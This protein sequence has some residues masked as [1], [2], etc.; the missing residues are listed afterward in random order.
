MKKLTLTN[1]G[2]FYIGKHKFKCYNTCSID[3]FLI[4]VYLL[5]ESTCEL[6]KFEEKSGN[7]F[8]KI[9]AFL[10]D[11]DWNMA[12]N[13]W[14]NFCP[15]LKHIQKKSNFNWFL[16]EFD[17]FFRYF[18]IYQTYNWESYCN[19]TREPPCYRNVKRTNE[20]FCFIFE[21]KLIFQHFIK[22]I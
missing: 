21:Y 15:D 6:G 11:N 12:R 9:F 5:V 18:R 3:Y 19:N 4:I 10:S 14:F 7:L 17:S 16:S 22:I 1:G 13:E 8:L 20:S 2:E